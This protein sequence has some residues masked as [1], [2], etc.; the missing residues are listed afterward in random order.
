MLEVVVWRHVQLEVLTT[1]KVFTPKLR[2]VA[3]ER[4]ACS[5]G[6]L[7][8]RIGAVIESHIDLHATD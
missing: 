4:G 5:V 7:V 8:A 2:M 1:W 3:A 6:V